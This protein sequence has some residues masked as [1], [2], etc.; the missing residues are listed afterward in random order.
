M[1]ILK[2]R[3]TSFYTRLTVTVSIVFIV[4]CLLIIFI[5]HE[6]YLKYSNQQYVEHV[7]SIG[8]K[9]AVLSQQP[10]VNK[11]K[12][13]L[14]YLSQVFLQEKHIHLIIFLDKQR[15]LI[16]T[17]TPKKFSQKR[18][19]KLL[20]KLNLNTGHQSH[21]I[22]NKFRWD[23]LHYPI[24]SDTN[25]ELQGYLLLGIDKEKA[26]A[27]FS[28]AMLSAIGLSFIV[29]LLGMFLLRRFGIKLTKPI[30]SLMDGTD[31]VSQGN[32]TY[33]IRVKEDG[34]LGQLARKFNEMTLK[35]NYY[36]KQKTLLNKKLHEYNEKLEEKIKERTHQLKKIQEEVLLIFHQIPVG[37]LVVDID[38]KIMWYNREFMKLLEIPGDYSI[39]SKHITEVQNIQQSG[40]DGIL[41]DLSRRA[42]KQVVQKQLSVQEGKHAQILEIASQPLIREDNQWDGT[43]FIIK[44]VTKDVAFEEK[45]RQE[46]RL[47]SVGEI[48]GGIAHDF[49]NIL[50][51]ILP[52]AQLLRL[53]LQDHPEWVKYLETIE[54]AADQAGWLTRQILAFSRGNAREKMEVINPNQAIEE[55]TKMFRRVL[56]R[57]IE[58][59]KELEP[60]LPNIKADLSQ[61]E[62]I[63]MNLAVNAR[64]AMPNG[65]RL[66]F[67]TLAISVD[68][69]GKSAMHPNLVPGK[70]V[71]LE[72][73]DTGIGIPKADLDKIF[74]PFFSSKKEGKGT[75]LGLS[76]VYGIMRSHGGI[77]DVISKIEQGT[78]FRL[79][80]P[81][82][83]E[84]TVKRKSEERE[85]ESGNETL[86]I[87][88]DEEMIQD[89]LS[90][91]LESL[92][93]RIISARNGRE[94]VDVFQEHREEIDAVLM[95][96]QMPEMDGVEAATKILEVDSN[97][98]IIFSSGY[99]DPS[100]FEKLK[101]MGYQFFLKKPYRIGIL[102]DIIRRAL[103]QEPSVN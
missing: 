67:R 7:E 59:K 11:N 40:L 57:K 70:Y 14:N 6:M 12:A 69:E 77:I 92:N 23:I 71:C 45:L 64:D 54:K 61:M 18:L 17:S 5:T 85:I 1:P 20:P 42:T 88:D 75:G 68:R 51:I 47:E 98:R 93:Y 44:D 96:I 41:I 103:V 25:Q 15:N 46:Q 24:E 76:V 99:A 52:N 84:E 22:K 74:D 36:N 29:L 66:I 33:Q 56:D 34:D 2:L 48:A 95:D 73:E 27:M 63:L 8:G 72:I 38:S 97:A 9:L 65:G 31:Q 3:K 10:I 50:A 19:S 13:E 79:F 30:R 39:S 86:L 53:K 35:L 83:Q 58:I 28:E 21:L 94:A 82:S 101:E 37:L 32:F 26:T 60:E 102:S 43:I 49:N 100:R 91:M 87:V 62:Q 4:V 81:A 89:T 55:F 80:F 90:S 78:Q 16:F